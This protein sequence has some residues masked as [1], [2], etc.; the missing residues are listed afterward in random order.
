M[1]ESNKETVREKFLNFLSKFTLIVCNTFLTRINK[2]DQ[3]IKCGIRVDRSHFAFEA[4]TTSNSQ[5]LDKTRVHM[6]DLWTSKRAQQL[7]NLT[8]LKKNAQAQFKMIFNRADHKL[9]LSSFDIVKITRTKCV[10]VYS[11]LISN[12]TISKKKYSKWSTYLCDEWNCLPLRVNS[13]QFS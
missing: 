7:K 13:R 12:L 1:R 11:S 10:V 6:Y 4:A 2:H 8:S 5:K 3:L 9:I